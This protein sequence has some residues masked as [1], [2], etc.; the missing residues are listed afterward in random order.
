MTGVRDRPTGYS[1]R[2]RSGVD[3]RRRFEGSGLLVSGSNAAAVHSTALLPYRL[4]ARRT[5]GLGVPRNQHHLVRAGPLPGKT[6]L[7]GPSDLD[8]EST[9]P[10]VCRYRPAWGPAAGRSPKLLWRLPDRPASPLPGPAD[11]RF[12][13]RAFATERVQVWRPHAC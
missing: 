5:G 8:P 4:P 7:L 11:S 13:Q 10:V 2:P 12:P 1:P 9:L 6:I 3:T